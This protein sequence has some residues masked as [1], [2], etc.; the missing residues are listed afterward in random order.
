M[1]FVYSSIRRFALSPFHL[2]AC[3]HLLLSL[4]HATPIIRNIAI[5]GNTR[6]RTEIIQRELLF[7]SGQP[8]DTLNISETERNLRRLFFLGNVNI[9]IQ[10]DSTFADLTIQV[11]DLYARALSPLLAGNTN[12]LSYGFTALDYNFLGRGQISQLTLYHDAITG[13]RARLFYRNP[14]LNNSHH[15]VTSNLGIANE[16]HHA[17]VSL[18]HPF[19]ALATPWN[20]GFNIYDQ[21]QIQRRYRGGVLNDKYSDCISGGNIWFI[22]SYGNT[23]KARPG[24]QL[25]LSD[26]RFTP[27]PSYTY[28]PQNRRRTLPSFTFTLWKPQYEKQAFIRQLGRTEDLQI[29]SSLF[30][31][32]GISSKTL[33]SDQNFLFYTLQITPRLKLTSNTFAFANFSLSGRHQNSTYADLFAQANLTLYT[34]I[35]EI[36]VI[37]FRARYNTLS[38]PE[39]N[40]QLLLGLNRGLRG[41]LPRRFDGTRRYTLNLEARPTLYQNRAFIIGSALFLDAGDAWTPNQSAASFNTAA[42]FGLRLASTRVYNQPILRTDLAYAFKDRTWQIS[43]GLGHYF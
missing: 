33:S 41:Y 21:K 17:I 16:G 38:R 10:R 2:L 3:L 29:G 8:L 20:Y 31:R 11:K 25:T 1:G 35:Q 15:T 7:Q 27:E 23:V 28:T 37:A 4:T 5:E 30:T 40:D 14:R 34:R 18:T 42:G 32:V 12:E 43:L 22:R 9:H 39:D 6:T 26:R 13:N 36:H 24:F 19:Y